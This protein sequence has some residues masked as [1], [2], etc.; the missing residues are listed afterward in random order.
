M[1]HAHFIQPVTVCQTAVALLFLEL[2]PATIGYGSEPVP[3]IF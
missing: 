1:I 3:L 2:H